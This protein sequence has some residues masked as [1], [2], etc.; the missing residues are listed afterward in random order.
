MQLADPLRFNVGLAERVLEYSHTHY[1][2]F[3]QFSSDA[4]L[5]GLA[6]RMGDVTYTSALDTGTAAL[7]L[8]PHEAVS[9]FVCFSRGYAND[10]FQSY[11]DQARRAQQAVLDAETTVGAMAGKLRGERRRQLMLR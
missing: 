8:M 10:Q 11:I 2:P 1:D 6:A 4:C 3:S 9:I 5:I 7:G